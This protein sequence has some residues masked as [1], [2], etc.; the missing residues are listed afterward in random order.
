MGIFA[1]RK[2]TAP[3]K[4]KAS[5][6][7]L[8]PI[9][10]DDQVRELLMG[11][12]HLG[13]LGASF[14]GLLTDPEDALK[15][16]E[17]NLLANAGMHTV[18]KH[19]TVHIWFDRFMAVASSSELSV[20]LAYVAVPRLARHGV[21][22]EEIA[23]KFELM[24]SVFVMAQLE[25]VDGRVPTP[26]PMATGGAPE[27]D[28]GHGIGENSIQN[29]SSTIKQDVDGILHDTAGNGLGELP[30]GGNPDPESL[31][32]STAETPEVRIRA[33][34]RRSRR[35]QDQTFPSVS[36]IAG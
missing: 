9:S 7:T 33:T 1:P 2:A 20:A 18:L 6:P 23:A 12:M 10:T 21:L 24:L 34:Q 16:D 3:A 19:P 28:R 36:E 13:N 29:E 32:R 11:A 22:P 31:R 14:T 26:A 17:I 27:P 4:R 5:R 30:G 8:K 15:P 35:S 25:G